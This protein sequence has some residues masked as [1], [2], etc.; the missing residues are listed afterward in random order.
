MRPRTRLPSAKELKEA[1]A[2][3]RQEVL[4]SSAKAL[5]DIDELLGGEC[6]A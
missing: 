5:Q 2:K 4:E 3:K 6:N 1:A